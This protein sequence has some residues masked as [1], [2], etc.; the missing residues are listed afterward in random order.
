VHSAF[1]FLMLAVAVAMFSGHEV[2]AGR[3]SL[4]GPGGVATNLATR[5][6][7]VASERANT[8]S[9]F[10]VNER[11]IATVQLGKQPGYIA[12]D[13]LLN[14]A[15]VTHYTCRCVSVIDGATYRKVGEVL[16]LGNPLGLAVH[17]LTGRVFIATAADRNAGG[18]L[19]GLVVVDGLT[20]RRVGS[21]A[22]RTGPAGVAVHPLNNWVYL[23]NPSR[24]SISIVDGV[25]FR[26]LTTVEVPSVSD[27]V[28]FNPSNGYVYAPDTKGNKVSVLDGGTLLKPFLESVD[29]GRSPASLAIDAS[30]N[31]IFVAN[32]ADRT[33]SVLD[34][35]THRILETIAVEGRRSIATTGGIDV[36]PASGRGFITHRDEDFVSSFQLPQRTK[37]SALQLKQTV[38]DKIAQTGHYKLESYGNTHGWVGVSPDP[39]PRGNNWDYHRWELVFDLPQNGDVAEAAIDLSWVADAPVIN[40]ALSSYPLG[41]IPQARQPIKYMQPGVAAW[42]EKLAF[43]DGFTYTFPIGE[44]AA[45]Q[46]G[47][48]SINLVSLGFG[49]HVQNSSQ[50]KVV[51]T[52]RY[53]LGRAYLD[54]DGSNNWQKAKGWAEWCTSYAVGTGTLTASGV[55]NMAL[56]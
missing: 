32:S 43:S 35:K 8:V 5:Q 18:T 53:T 20:N 45:A 1:R 12:V 56:Q 42:I 7:Y 34:G 47:S 14:K 24:K 2:A 54:D 16:V 49:Q 55:M 4:R 25:A 26:L 41:A 33:I 39:N 38:T 6:F 21:L 28:A 23:T 3:M 11:L 44:G 36:M 31:R 51:G 27:D 37:T 9:V 13:P 48:R 15:Y 22:L 29:V 30:A 46:T 40:P 50:V 10:D 52:W 19:D 17:P